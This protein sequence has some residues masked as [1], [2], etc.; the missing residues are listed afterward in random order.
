MVALS[1]GPD[2]VALVH[3][4]RELERAGELALAGLAHFNHQLRAADADQDEA[5]CR[6][7]AGRLRLPIEVGRGDVR[8]LALDE[9]RS[10]EDAAR[11]ARY[12]FLEEAAD[13]LRADAIAVGHSRDD[14]AETFLLRLVRGSGSRGLASI[15]PRN[16]RVIRPMLDISRDELRDYAGERNLPFR[17]DAT[18]DDQAIPRNRVRHEL[19]PYL[20][21]EFSPGIAGLLARA[22]AVAREDDDCL[23]AQAIELARSI[24]LVTEDG[25]EVD[26]ARLMAL[27]PALAARV[28]QQALRA[29][30]DAGFIGFDHVERF[31]EFAGQGRPGTMMSLP[32]QQATHRG[33]RVALGP[34]PPRGGGA[35]AANSFDFS[36][37]IP[38]EVTLSRQGWAIG[39]EPLPAGEP[40]L[41]FRT[42]RGGAVV[43]AL[44]PLALP[45]RVRGRKPGDRF[46]PLGL[47]G[48]RKKLQDFF[49]DRKIPRE[50]RDS[51]PIV[52]DADDRVVWVVGESIA[53]DFRVTEPSQG[54]LL[55]KA[56][57]LGGLG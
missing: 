52:V 45:L 43:V 30:S 51:L 5:F 38:G 31:L 3:L 9:G 23:Q 50:K 15:L 36:L 39:V 37:S 8:A 28:A 32:G 18:N 6:A 57:R 1:G 27:H 24:V 10:V 41:E 4:L 49:V 53:E 2:S 42:G 34:E 40:G 11:V 44:A 55:L 17:T 48:Q 47:G 33:A 29:S 35:P 12:A 13:R 46:A 7:M 25:I 19:L 22:A 26:C 16:G 20:E 56:R 54:V 14:Q 21:R